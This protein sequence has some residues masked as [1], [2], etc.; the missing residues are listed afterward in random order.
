MHPTAVVA[1]ALFTQDTAMVKNASIILL[2]ADA[3]SMLDPLTLAD[4][5]GKE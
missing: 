5:V 1:D 2:S 4:H 3:F